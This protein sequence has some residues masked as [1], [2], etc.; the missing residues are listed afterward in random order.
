MKNRRKIELESMCFLNLAF[1]AFSDD[2]G[3]I[4]GR[5]GPSKNRGKSF[6]ISKKAIVA[7]I[8]FVKEVRLGCCMNLMPRLKT[9]FGVNPTTDSK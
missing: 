3:S 2:F 6:K 9:K 4:L 7:H 1:L 5:P 8:F